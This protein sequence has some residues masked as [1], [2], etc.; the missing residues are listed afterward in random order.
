MAPPCLSRGSRWVAPPICGWSHPSA[1]PIK[2]PFT[3]NLKNDCLWPGAGDK[4]LGP[5][6][7]EAPADFSRPSGLWPWGSLSQ[8]DVIPEAAPSESVLKFWVLWPH[9][10]PETFWEPIFKQCRYWEEF[11]SLYICVEADIHHQNSCQSHFSSVHL[12]LRCCRTL[13]TPFRKFL[14]YIQANHSSE[15]NFPWCSREKWPEFRS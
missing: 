6:G 15:L 7:C 12:V 8:V 11:C 10:S 14:V 4:I 13:G 2:T 3:E 9:T 5:R 1:Q